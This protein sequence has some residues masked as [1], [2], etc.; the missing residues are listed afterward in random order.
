MDDVRRSRGDA[1]LEAP[2]RQ[3]AERR[4]DI[5]PAPVQAD[6]HDGV[7]RVLG[8]QPVAA[9]GLLPCPDLAGEAAAHQGENRRHEHAGRQ[10]A[11]GVGAPAGQHLVERVA[12]DDVE[13]VV[14]EPAEAAQSRDLVQR[15]DVAEAARRLAGGDPAGY[16]S[17][18][19]VGAGVR[20]GG[21]R[22]RDDAPAHGYQ[23]DQA[24]GAHREAA[25]EILQ[26]RR[27]D[28]RPHDPGEAA[29]RI[30]DPARHRDAPLPVGARADGLAD[31]HATVRMGA[32]VL[33]IGA[34]LDPEHADQG[35]PL[36]GELG[37]PGVK[38]RQAGERRHVG[39][40]HRDQAFQP[41]RLL[42]RRRLRLDLLAQ[43]GQD[44]VGD[45]QGVA[46]MLGERVGE[47]RGLDLVGG[48]RGLA[49][50]PGAPAVEPEQQQ[51]HRENGRHDAGMQ[52]D[53]AASPGRKGQL[54]A[55]ER[56]A[57]GVRPTRP[58]MF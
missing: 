2:S 31:L 26:E 1:L 38:H 37:P 58:A 45:A 33:E 15:R 18:G 29:L 34:I 41:L 20:L 44:H 7:A 39:D 56:P 13:R 28:P 5:A 3:P 27:R 35:V 32:V 42:R 21:I 50:L 51:A 47:V 24:S 8:Q 14:V 22:A 11:P 23:R 25:V 16:R 46:G 53:A 19:H 57:P 54:H 17:A 49:R 4:R 40:M 10:V 48:D 55:V 52:R 12:D 6:A 43:P 30:V 9:F 36:P